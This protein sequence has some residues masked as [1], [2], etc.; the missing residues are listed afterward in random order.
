[1]RKYKKLVSTVLFCSFSLC[2]YKISFAKNLLSQ[3]SIS[4]LTSINGNEKRKQELDK[5][6]K[7]AARKKAIKEKISFKKRMQTWKEERKLRQKLKKTQKEKTQ[8]QLVVFNDYYSRNMNKYGSNNW[9][10]IN[11]IA[12]KTAEVVEKRRRGEASILAGA[13]ILFQLSQILKGYKDL[14]KLSST[15]QKSLYVKL[16]KFNTDVDRCIGALKC[17]NKIKSS[18]YSQSSIDLTTLL[19]KKFPGKEDLIDL[20]ISGHINST[21]CSAR[22]GA[23]AGA[24]FVGGYLGAHKL[25]CKTPF[26]RRILYG[27]LSTSVGIGIGGFVAK[28]VSEY[29]IN[30]KNHYQQKTISYPK[31]RVAL[32]AFVLA[33]VGPGLNLN[34]SVV[35][36][37]SEVGAGAALI[38]GVGFSSR[39][40]IK[41]LRH[42]FRELFKYLDIVAN[43]QSMQNIY[44]QQIK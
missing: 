8:E 26:G 5:E 10:R 37:S 22:G 1:M 24:F 40:K 42:D 18:K 13:N 39:L 36:S 17:L 14:D 11:S 7:V 16:L 41:D 25:K 28:S 27:H 31:S 2:S 9:K 19:Y 29:E 33:A 4:D 32:N 44:E 30:S 43:T 23:A 12:A 21:R 34:T 35:E 38:E 20:F 6:A 15:Q 3:K